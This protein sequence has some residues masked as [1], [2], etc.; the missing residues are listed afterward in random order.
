M[1]NVLRGNSIVE[2]VACGSI[3]T[4]LQEIDIPDVSGTHRLYLLLVD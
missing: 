3:P 1:E 2:A 4:L